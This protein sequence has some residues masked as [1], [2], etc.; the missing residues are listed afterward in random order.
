MKN[1]YLNRDLDSLYSFSEKYTFGDDSVYERIAMELITYRNG[2]MVDG[3]LEY[4]SSGIT[5]IAV[6][7]MHLPGE[8]GILNQ[9]ELRAYN[10]EKI[11]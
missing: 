2:K 7:A 5:F 9:L 4:L 6:G 8:D 11:Y 10:I 1:H 3:I